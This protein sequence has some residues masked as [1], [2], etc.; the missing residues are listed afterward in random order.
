LGRLA[1]AQD[2]FE[3]DNEDFG[4]AIGRTT[5]VGCSEYKLSNF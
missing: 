3:S 2:E 1:A 5:K 4:A